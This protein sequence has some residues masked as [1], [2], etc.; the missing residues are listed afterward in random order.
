M[1]VDMKTC[2]V[3][4][5]NP[6]DYPDFCDAYISYAEYANGEELDDE[7]LEK[8]NDEAGDWI[9]QYCLENYA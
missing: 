5:I 4:D 8:L 9:N 7:A 3:D 2:E 6:R 1:K